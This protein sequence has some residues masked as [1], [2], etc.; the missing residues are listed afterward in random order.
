MRVAGATL[1]LVAIQFLSFFCEKRTFMHTRSV[2]V[3]VAKNWIFYPRE[4]LGFFTRSVGELIFFPLEVSR[5][6][7]P[8]FHGPFLSPVT[9]LTTKDRVCINVRFSQKMT[10]IE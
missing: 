1:I 7:L 4:K 9:L 2:V 3:T 6:T 5:L 8:P 10:K